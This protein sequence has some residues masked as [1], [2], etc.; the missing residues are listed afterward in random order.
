VAVLVP[1]AGY[2]DGHFEIG[3]DKVTP[4]RISGF[5]VCMSNG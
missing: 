5:A 1:Q 4:T 3:F 2:C